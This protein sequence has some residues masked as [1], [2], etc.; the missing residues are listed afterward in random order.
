MVSSG[1]W[2]VDVGPFVDLASSSS[3]SYSA[4]LPLVSS[5]IPVLVS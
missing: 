3:L 1:T 4:P 2:L 5:A